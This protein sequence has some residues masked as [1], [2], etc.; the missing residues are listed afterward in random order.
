MASVSCCC[1]VPAFRCTT[2]NRKM[3]NFSTRWYNTS[4]CQCSFNLCIAFQSDSFTTA[5]LLQCRL[6]KANLPAS[7]GKHPRGSAQDLAYLQVI[8]RLCA[9]P[10]YREA[11]ACEPRDCNP[12][13]G[14]CLIR[15]AVVDQFNFHEP[16]FDVA[17]GAQ[18]P[19][20]EAAG[21]S[22]FSSRPS[23]GPLGSPSPVPSPWGRPQ[24]EERSRRVHH[25]RCFPVCHNRMQ[26]RFKLGQCCISATEHKAIYYCR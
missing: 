4:A 24:S 7:N 26:D 10:L 17:T 1:S 21:P 8:D 14:D 15:V 3:T 19:V 11:I 6:I 16:P 12:A 23:R 20:A 25:V 9:S 13:T 2:H 5:D 18:P 22:N